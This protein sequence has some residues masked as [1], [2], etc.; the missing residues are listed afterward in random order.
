MEVR[1]RRIL[2]ALALLGSCSEPRQPATELIVVVDSDLTVPGEL[3]QIEVQTHGPGDSAQSANAALDD[4]EGALPRSLALRHLAGPLGPVS[5]QVEGKRAGKTVITREAEASFVEGQSLVLPLHLARSCLRT[6]CD[7]G[8]TC[9]EDGCR[10][11]AIDEDELD[12]WTGD[13]PHLWQRDAGE[14]EDASALD[15]GKDAGRASDAAMA[16]DASDAGGA[17]D[18]MVVRDAAQEAGQRDAAQCLPRAETCNGADDNCDGRIDDGFNLNTDV[19]NC[20]RCGTAC[21][22]RLCCRGT[23]ARTCP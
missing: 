4:G 1:F 21:N 22:G 23:C 19:N 6:S 20:G 9:T 12:D 7:D 14:E 2:L 18:A 17:R 8:E 3:D 10:A 15:A 13:K 5:I 16:S 11:V